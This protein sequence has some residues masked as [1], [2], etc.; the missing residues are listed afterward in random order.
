MMVVALTFMSHLCFQTTLDIM[1]AE[2][3]SNIVALYLQVL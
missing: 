3:I 1:Q 2:A